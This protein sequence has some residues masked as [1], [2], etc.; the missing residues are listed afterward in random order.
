ME[1]TATLPSLENVLE[2]IIEKGFE[3]NTGRGY[4]NPR[5]G[6]RFIGRSMGGGF[7]FYGSGLKH[8][9][10]PP[11]DPLNQMHMREQQYL[12]EQARLE[13]ESR[14]RA[15]TSLTQSTDLYGNRNNAI[16]HERI[17]HPVQQSNTLPT[18]DYHHHSNFNTKPD[19]AGNTGYGGYMNLNVGGAPRVKQTMNYEIKEFGLSFQEKSE[20]KQSSNWLTTNQPAIK[21]DF[22]QNLLNNFSFSDQFELKNIKKN[23]YMSLLG[24]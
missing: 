15:L 16:L 18:I 4:L 8:P 3:Y 19:P 9:D 22:A 7:E 17:F 11:C 10:L 5:N 12:A 14:Q 20:M 6:G 1:R 24:K 13:E 23:N 21:Q 2:N